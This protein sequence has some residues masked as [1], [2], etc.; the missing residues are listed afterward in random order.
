MPYGWLQYIKHSDLHIWSLHLY[1][2]IACIQPVSHQ[3][4][5]FNTWN[6]RCLPYRAVEPVGPIELG[7][8]QEQTRLLWATTEGSVRPWGV[9]SSLAVL[10]ILCTAQCWWCRIAFAQL[11]TGQKA[12]AHMLCQ[13]ASGISV[14]SPE[15]VLGLHFTDE[16]KGS[17]EVGGPVCGRSSWGMQPCS[18]GGHASCLGGRLGQCGEMWHGS[19]VCTSDWSFKQDMLGSCHH[20]TSW[21]RESLK[22]PFLQCSPLNLPPLF[23]VRCSVL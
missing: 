13:W 22:F 2:S 9:Q 3:L 5:S 15:Q 11:S 6:I 4:G 16:V 21:C 1:R 14:K 8:L 7:H 20:I 19:L 18:S 17:K 10:A 23:R 12:L